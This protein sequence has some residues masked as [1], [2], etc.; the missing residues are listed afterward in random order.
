MIHMRVRWVSRPVPAPRSFT[1]TAR[2]G[3]PSLLPAILRRVPSYY[4]DPDAP[5]PNRPMRSGVVALI[6][7][8]DAVLLERRRDDG[9]WGLV[10]GAIAA[11]ETVVE[12]LVREVREETGLATRE[13]ELFGVFSDPSRIVGYADGNVYRVLA[14]AFRVEVEDG[15]AEVS[16]ESHEV[17]FVPCTDILELDLGPAHRPIVERFLTGPTQLVVE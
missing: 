8:D 13:V 1:A 10:G 15:I 11:D 14:I 9:K 7:S 2:S 6:E 12:A 3:G 5:T 4:R 17:L 16:E